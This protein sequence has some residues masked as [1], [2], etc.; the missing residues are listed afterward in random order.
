MLLTRY[1]NEQTFICFSPVIIE[2]LCLLFYHQREIQYYYSPK[3]GSL[4]GTSC[5]TR[6]APQSIHQPWYR[7]VY[8]RERKYKANIICYN[9]TTLLNSYFGPSKASAKIITYYILQ[10]NKNVQ[11]AKENHFKAIFC[12][13]IYTCLV[14]LVKHLQKFH[15]LIEKIIDFDLQMPTTE[16]PL[17]IR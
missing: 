13:R 6:N 4:A 11:N 3:K 12:C 14:C 2:F 17:F 7:D 1:V 9:L 10:M 5:F 8:P 15:I 16:N